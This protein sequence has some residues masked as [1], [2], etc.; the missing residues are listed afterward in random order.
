M[1]VLIFAAGFG[2]QFLLALFVQRVMGF[3]A[4]RTGLAFLP[5]PVAI[6]VV[7]LLVAPRLTARFG[8]RPV[9]LAGLTVLALGL[10]AAEPGAGRSV[11]S[12]RRPARR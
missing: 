12:G 10:A 11:L 3:D 1:V 8:P 5:T 9:L 6:G 4:L 7:S 2:F